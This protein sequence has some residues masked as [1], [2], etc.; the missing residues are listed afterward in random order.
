[1]MIN[2]MVNGM[3]IRRMANDG[4]SWHMMDYL[5]VSQTWIIASS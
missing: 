4:K 2:G 1:M 5:M 3:D